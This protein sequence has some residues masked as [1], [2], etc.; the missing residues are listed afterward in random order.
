MGFSYSLSSI[1]YSLY[2]QRLTKG[3]FIHI[4]YLQRKSMID[5]IP[6]IEIDFWG[7]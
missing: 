1:A 7:Q 6:K 2:F 4:I 3:G 5:A